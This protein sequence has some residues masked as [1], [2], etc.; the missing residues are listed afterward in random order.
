VATLSRNGIPAGSTRGT[1][2]RATSPPT[3]HGAADRATRTRAA[4]QATPGELDRGGGRGGVVEIQRARMI[5]ALIE[6][7]RERGAGGVTVAHVVAR[8]GVSR[9]T[10]YELFEDR[11]DCFLAAF[12]LAVERAAQRVLP[13]FEAPGSW[14]ER[15][16]A[17]L[18]ALLEFL[19][20]EPGMGA[21]CIVDVLGAGPV[22]LERRARVVE[23][24][25][26]AVDG[27]RG[28]ARGS[29]QPTRLTAEGVV[30]AVLA[31]L[32]A[33][34]LQDDHDPVCELLGPL[35]GVIVMPYQGAAAAARE[36]AKPAPRRG[37]SAHAHGDPLR[38]LDMRLS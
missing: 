23:Q 27:G 29:V 15:V 9:R 33:R 1:A 12:D 28:E 3:T 16:R 18:G 6:V 4:K 32:H 19:E 5:A 17:G 13:A 25:I 31:I 37:P 34:M 22:A 7:A 30:G 20:D 38:D 26:D 2:D 24:L 35:M 14:R 36:A 21:L 11:E 10:F 8:S